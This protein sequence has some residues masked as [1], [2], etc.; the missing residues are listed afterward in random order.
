MVRRV[1]GTA[2]ISD[3]APGVEV[4][5]FGPLRSRCSKY[6]AGIAGDQ[7]RATRRGRDASRQKRGQS[8]RPGR[9]RPTLGDASRES[10]RP[11]TGADLPV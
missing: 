6:R 1:P 11:A 4:I 10:G 7:K 3:A 2:Q 9:I 5:F 8:R